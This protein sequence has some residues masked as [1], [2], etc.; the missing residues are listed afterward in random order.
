MGCGR[1]SSWTYHVPAG[2]I[3][4][5][6]ADLAAVPDESGDLEGSARSDE[7]PTEKMLAKARET[8]IGVKEGVIA[9]P[10]FFMS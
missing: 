7:T 8:W 1:F 9:P 4:G 5:E 6:G 3:A 10:L 2:S